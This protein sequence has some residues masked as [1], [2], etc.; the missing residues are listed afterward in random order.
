MGHPKKNVD[1]FGATRLAREAEKGNMKFVREAY[2][3]A[4]EE[5]DQSDFAGF[6]PLQKAALNGHADVV[7]FLLKK[8][9][10]TDCHS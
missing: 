9:C 3:L 8:G 5:L 7:E 6:A 2:D 10:R 1:K 4:P